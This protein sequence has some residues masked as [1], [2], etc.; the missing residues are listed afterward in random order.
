M[1][2]RENFN[3]ANPRI[4]RKLR[5]GAEERLFVKP[6]TASN[7]NLSISSLDEALKDTEESDSDEILKQEGFYDSTD[8]RSCINRSRR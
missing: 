5:K 8:K 1:D 6:S 2:Y 3:Y 4:L 7:I